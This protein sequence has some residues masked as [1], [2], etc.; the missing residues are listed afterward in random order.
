MGYE[1]FLSL[2]IWWCSVVAPVVAIYL[3]FAYGVEPP[4]WSGYITLFAV[5]AWPITAVWGLIRGVIAYQEEHDALGLF[6]SGTSAAVIV[7]ILV[8]LF[9]KG[10][11]G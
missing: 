4:T 3:V 5:V 7:F 9:A 10:V 2:C 6:L 1:R 11:L 8:L